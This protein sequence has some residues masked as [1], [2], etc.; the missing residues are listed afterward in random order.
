MSIALFSAALYTAKCLIIS[1]RRLLPGPNIAS[2]NSILNACS[3]GTWQEV[4]STRAAGISLEAGRVQDGPSAMQGAPTIWAS[5]RRGIK[6][7]D[8]QHDEALNMPNR[9]GASN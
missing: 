7:Y 6:S 2:Y 9:A 5:K 1:L 3:E 8:V 4:R